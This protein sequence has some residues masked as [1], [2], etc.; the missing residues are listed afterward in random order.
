MAPPLPV[1]R[2]TLAVL[3]AGRKVSSGARE[4]GWT[5]QTV[6]VPVKSLAESL[7]DVTVCASFSLRYGYISLLGEHTSRATAMRYRDRALAG[8]LLIE[9]LRP[10]R[11]SWAS[12]AVSIARR[13][14]LG[15]AWSGT[16]VALLAVGMLIAVIVL[17][18]NL[19][20]KE[21]R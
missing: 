2:V 16:W 21:L 17:A 3:V 15:R 4:A 19:L 13:M 20:Q 7:P 12:M 18:V 5:S 14:G 10:A 11:R 9:Y 8:R 1:P 6:T